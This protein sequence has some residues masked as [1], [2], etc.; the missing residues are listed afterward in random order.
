M[1]IDPGEITGLA[2]LADGKVVDKANC[3]S[4]RETGN[5]IKGIVKNV[6]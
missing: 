4:I 1:G 5:K 3:L 6:N 2:V